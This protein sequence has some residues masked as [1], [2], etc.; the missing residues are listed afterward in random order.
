MSRVLGDPDALEAYTAEVRQS[1]D[2]ASSAVDGYS[3]AVAS[4]NSASPNDLGTSITNLAVVIEADLDHLAELDRAPAAFAFALRNIDH[5]DTGGWNWVRVTDLERFDAL[6]TAWLNNPDAS[7]QD[8]IAAAHGELDTSIVWP[9]NDEGEWVND[10][11]SATWWASTAIGVSTKTVQEVW[12]TWGV[13]VRG[14]YRGNT[15]VDGHGRWRP[16]WAQRLNPALG[17]ASS[18][19]RAF[20]H[21]RVLGR[22]VPFLPGVEQVIS[23]WNDPTLTTGDRIA[24][25]GFT[26][27]L[28]GGLGAL[29][30]FGGAIGGA[31]LGGLIGT[32]T[33]SP[34]VGTAIGGAAGAVGGAMIG[35]SIGAE[36]GGFINDNVQGLVESAGR[37]IDSV[38]DTVTSWF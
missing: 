25:T 29:G 24:R 38:I 35:G 6:A 19:Q 18:W 31:A 34:V 14:H 13:D 1:V 28:E 17:R 5:L 3:T 27:G 26:L 9:W 23:D 2:D 15:H 33:A 12:S 7:E 16:G 22:V 10:P 32:F 11:T 30:A 36:V 8:I 20:R 37:G 4:F 21:S